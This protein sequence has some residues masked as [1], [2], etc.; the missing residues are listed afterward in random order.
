MYTSSEKA[1]TTALALARRGMA[2]VPLCWPTDGSRCGCGRGHVGGE[3][4]KA[5]AVARGLHAATTDEATL[6]AWWRAMP[7]ANIGVRTGRASG[8]VVVDVDPAKG[9]EVAL[10]QLEA[11]HGPLP[12]TA[13]VATGG[14]G[15]HLWFAAPEGAPVPCSAGRLGPGLDVRGE[16]GYVVAP[17]SRHASGGRYVWT[18]PRGI[19][20]APLPPWLAS[21][22][23]GSAAAAEDGRDGHERLDVARVL[24]G[25]PEGERNDQLFRLAAKLRAA[26]VPREVAERLA[27][28]AAARCTP[29]LPEA[30]ALQCVASAYGRYPPGNGRALSRPG[31]EGEPP[32]AWQPVAVAELPE[33]PPRRWVLPGLLPAD[34]LSLWY[35]DGGTFKSFVALALAVAKA[36]GRE[37]LGQPLAPG[38]VLFVDAELDQN[39]FARRTYGVARGLGLQAPPPGL[40]YLRLPASLAQEGALATL[41]TVAR[42]CRAELVVVDSLT[43]ASIGLDLKEAVD[44]SAVLAGLARLGTTLVLD[45]IPKPL[46]G[47]NLS[48]YRPFGSFAKWALARHVVQ[49][50]RAET[51]AGLILRPAKANFGPLGAPVGVGIR[52]DGDAVVVERADL[53][54]DALAGVE[55]H[56]PAV[57]RV[58]RALAECSDGA[59]PAEL[60]EALDM[61]EGRVRNYLTALRRQG[62]AEALGDGRWRLSPGPGPLYQ[63]GARGNTSRQPDTSSQFTALIR[64]VNCENISR[65]PDMSAP[66]AGAAGGVATATPAPAPPEAAGAPGAPGAAH[67]LALA[68]AAGWPRLPLA[69]WLAVGPGE[70]AWRRFARW[71]SAHDHR[72]ALEALERACPGS[73]G[74]PATEGLPE[75]P[76]ALRLRLR[77]LGEALG[78]R[79]LPP[80]DGH[81]GVE[82]GFTAWTEA[83]GRPVGELRALV[84]DAERQL[85]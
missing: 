37:F 34:C 73:A 20:I 45:H 77:A 63:D 75:H 40:Y 60:A 43:F 61:S 70:E 12:P 71:A 59:T 51:G 13:E 10:A 50:I 38:P 68:E 66:S 22:M 55:E 78:Y 24:A 83:Q 62:R 3:V 49:V 29:P 17:P 1:M 47:A 48:Q 21:L 74:Q 46:P 57:E 79:G 26:D 18:S 81:R 67:L 53:G 9:G 52:F 2:V 85:T 25:V 44:A 65:Q 54:N 31:W 42:T 19:A 82:P 72:R 69:P 8:I 36:A 11:R 76:L 7:N 4:G 56:L 23:R 39:E 64:A 15:R 30:E 16:G 35:G 80:G 32:P 14:G 27:L 84:R 28:E 6:R 5:P 58:A 41:Q 33:P